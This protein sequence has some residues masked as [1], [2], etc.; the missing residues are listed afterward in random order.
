MTKKIFIPLVTKTI[1]TECISFSTN[2]IFLGTSDLRTPFFSWKRKLATSGMG[3]FKQKLFTEGTS[4]EFVSLIS[5]AQRPDT[6]A[7]YESN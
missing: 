1:N 7:H 4:K 2:P 6:F 5:G 3:S